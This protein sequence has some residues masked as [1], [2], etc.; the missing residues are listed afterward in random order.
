VFGSSYSGMVPAVPRLCLPALTFQDGPAGV[1]GKLRGVTQLPAPIAVAAT[2][3]TGAGTAYGALLGRE[4]RGKGT[5]VTLAPTINLV[6]DPR[7]GRAFESTGEDPYLAGAIGAS[8]VRGIQSAGQLAQVKHLAVYNQE[9]NRNTEADDAVVSTRAMQELY[10]PAFGTVVRDGAVASAMCSYSYVNGIDAC[11]NPYLMTNVLRQQYGFTGFVTSDW[12][13]TKSVVP[14]AR[15]GLD[16]EMPSGIF[17]GAS[18]KNAVLGGRF[19]LGTLNA[20]VSRILRQAFGFG[21]VDRSPVGSPLHPVATAASAAMAGTLAAEGTVLLKNSAAALPLDPSVHSIAVIGDDASAHPVYAGGGSANVIGPYGVSPLVGLRRRAPTGV[22][23]SFD[24]GQ[25]P[26]TAAAM[27][28]QAEVAVVFAGQFE[29]E[30]SDLSTLGLPGN[31]DQVISAVGAANPRTIVVLNT[32]SAVTMP[33]LGRVSAVLEAWYPGQEDGNAIARVLYGDVNPSGHLPLTFPRSLGDVPAH[34]PAQWPGVNGSVRY[35]E[36][37]GIGYRWYDQRAIEPLFPFGYGLSYTSFRF[38]G[39]TVSPIGP[40]GVA[41]VAVT[42]TNTGKRAGA[43]V[44]QLYVSHPAAAGEP[45]RILRGF[46]RV[47]LAPGATTRVTLP[48]S[49]HDLAWFDQSRGDFTTSTGGYGVYV[50][51]SS[52]TL[53]LHATL[54]VS[55]SAAARTVT[56]TNPGPLDL[57][58]KSAA[59]QSFSA[60]AS[61][62]DR[63][64]FTASG[65]PPGLSVS[66]DGQLQGAPSAAGTSTATVTASD[67]AGVRGSATF[68]VTVNSADGPGGP[69]GEITGL[70]R[71]C[72]DVRGDSDADG[73]AVQTFACNGS[74]AQQWTIRSDGTIRALGRCLDVAHGSHA[75]QA[76]VQLFS[77]NGSAAQQWRSQTGGALVNPASQKCLDVP[78]AS[79]APATQLDI[80][81]CSG[82][83]AQRWG[84]PS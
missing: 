16:L 83:A 43:D 53:P 80:F 77:C 57:T 84:L 58:A 48:L 9:T 51:D 5:V 23:V 14:A 37:L 46:Q 24:A 18:L 54:S 26:A 11:Q 20:M 64:T 42:V 71:L 47:G 12:Y 28:A 7:W 74:P 41:T 36:E 30:E 31:Q 13:G 25:S 34:T 10:L 32:G 40:G 2:W 6:R 50:G 62:N 56:V 21:L 79:T 61:S 75:D 22:R 55:S 44:V 73:T 60:H 15:A 45:P 65:L 8:L 69:L 82:T 78:R 66:R 76:A 52:R 19:P 39:L 38:G 35:S 59:H 68:V 29:G 27:A 33:W 4:Q 17:F 49:L 67:S 72:V 1:G 70:G 3:D 81:T 63:L